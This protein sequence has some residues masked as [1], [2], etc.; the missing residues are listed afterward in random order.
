[1][2]N[3]CD[4]MS[5]AKKNRLYYLNKRIYKYFRNKICNWNDDISDRKAFIDG[6]KKR[7]K[8]NGNN[9]RYD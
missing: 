9:T 3:T 8:E 6:I 4:N 1:M 5:C 7:S 2:T